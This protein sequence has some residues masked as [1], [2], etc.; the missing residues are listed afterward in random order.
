L[1]PSQ[2]ACRFKHREEYEDDNEETCR[3]EPHN[4]KEKRGFFVSPR[5]TVLA[6]QDGPDRRRESRTVFIWCFKHLAKA[7]TLLVLPGFPARRHLAGQDT[8]AGRE[9]IERDFLNDPNTQN[10][11]LKNRKSC[12]L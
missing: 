1:S 3:Q 9:R 7:R 6:R 4:R 8:G 2:D 11:L 10:A 12:Y 5:K